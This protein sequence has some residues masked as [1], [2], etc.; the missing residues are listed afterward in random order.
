MFTYS[1]L[2][3]FQNRIRSQIVKMLNYFEVGFTAEMRGERS[4]YEFIMTSGDVA[5]YIYD[6][7]AQIAGKNID[8]RYEIYDFDTEEELILNFI[9]QLKAIVVDNDIRPT[10]K[11]TKSI[12]LF[13]LGKI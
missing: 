11:S 12:D 10:G 9:Q 7:G 4:P 13:T 8:F 1:D 3:P 2:N 6:D 5:I